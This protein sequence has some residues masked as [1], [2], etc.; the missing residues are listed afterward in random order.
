MGIW[1]HTERMSDDGEGRGLGSQGLLTADRVG[2][3]RKEASLEAPEGSWSAHT[4]ISERW[5]M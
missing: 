1:R 5:P 2:G 3:D 4:M